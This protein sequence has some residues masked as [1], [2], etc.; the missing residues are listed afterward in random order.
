MY[1]I[2]HNNIS[3]FTDAS[4]NPQSKVG[5]GA[6]LFINNLE[7]YTENPNEGIL[8]KR[9]ENTSSTKLE[10]QTLLW[11]FS[12]LKSYPIQITV[13]TDSQNLCRL[14]ER[15]SQLEENKYRSKN[16]NRIH[17]AELYREFYRWHDKLKFT[18]TKV[19]GHQQLKNKNELD[20]LF[21]YVDRAARNALR[22]SN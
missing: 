8:L 9:F 11:A 5:F 4:V 7:S 2:R 13:Y 17:N 6:Y 20:K 19:K 22:T 12:Q 3:I 16:K 14:L 10:L 15:R 21:T 1:K 18:I